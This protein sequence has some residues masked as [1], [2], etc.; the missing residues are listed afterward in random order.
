MTTL[1]GAVTLPELDPLAAALAL[2]ASLGTGADAAVSDFATRLIDPVTVT[3]SVLLSSTIPETDYP[4]W[5]AAATYAIGDLVMRTT[6]HRVYVAL[7]AGIDSGTPETTP[8]RW[9]RVG[10]TNRWRMFD[11][12]VGSRSSA[13]G[14]LTVRLQPGYADA[15]ALLE[16]QASTAVVLVSD[17]TGRVKYAR[18]ADLTGLQ[19][20]DWWQYFTAEATPKTSLLLTGLPI[21]SG[22]VVDVSLYGSTVELGVLSIG[23]ETKLGLPQYGLG[24]G[25][26]DYSRKETDEFGE[27]SIVERAFA[28]RC[29]L[30]VAIERDATEKVFTKLAK[31]RA[32]NVVWIP[33][34]ASGYEVLSVYGFWKDVRVDVPY[35]TMNYCS[36]EIEGLI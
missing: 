3:D 5:S 27:T 13:S 11:E 33:S 18:V 31:L 4:A 35:P 10:S 9:K 17:S 32:K 15:L 30:R 8:A 22:D 19:V 21:S 28:K 2:Q 1:S 36:I 12:S 26:A 20:V 16:M 14:S 24:L 25:I 23:T 29:T 7:V 6:T 34:P